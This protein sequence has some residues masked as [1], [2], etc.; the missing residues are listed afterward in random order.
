MKRIF[1]FLPCALLL[2]FSAAGQD[3]RALDRAQQ[4]AQFA[5]GPARDWNRGGDW[6]R[7]RYQVDRLGYMAGSVR[8]RM[9]RYGASRLEWIRM[10]QLRSDI[11][12]LNYKVRN[13][14]GGQGRI[15]SRIR[16]TR[17]ALH[18]IEMRLNFRPRDYYRW[19][20]R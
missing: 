14:A 7:L 2:A 11:A 10:S 19:D 5:P 13:R 16:D 18:Q 3:G 1:I 9:N 6:G 4:G 8:S 17:V 15:E 12:N 20:D